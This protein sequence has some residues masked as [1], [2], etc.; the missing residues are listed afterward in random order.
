MICQVTIQGFIGDSVLLPC[1]YN[2]GESLRKNVSVYWRDKDDNIVLDISK[3]GPDPSTQNHKFRDRVISF[4][5]VYMKG[6]FSILMKDVQPS[7]SSPYDCH[8]P[9]EDFQQRLL[10][11]V[12]GLYESRMLSEETFES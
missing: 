11:N 3:N 8:I 4:P 7:D 9:S 10:L 2:Q 12:S 5:H 6:N 1:I